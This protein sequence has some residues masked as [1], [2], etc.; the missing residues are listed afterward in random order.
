MQ[1]VWL[2]RNHFHNLMGKKTT[3]WGKHP[4]HLPHDGAGEG[5]DVLQRFLWVLSK[6]HSLRKLYLAG[7][8]Q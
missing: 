1:R 6:S 3:A 7:C 2:P 4:H 5:E 8:S